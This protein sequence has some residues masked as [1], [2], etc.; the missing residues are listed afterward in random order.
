ME[1]KVDK[2]IAIVLAGVLCMACAPS[3]AKGKVASA[4]YPKV[5]H[6]VWQADFPTCKLPG[7][8]DSDVR[9]EIKP[10]KLIDYEQWNSP[11][12]VIQISR[13][14]QAWKISSRVHIDE[15]TFDHEEIY[16]LSGQDNGQLTIVDGNRA[17][18]YAR[19]R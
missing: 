8:L 7:N 17:I 13:S 2:A 16:A 5:L 11:V 15:S 18:T 19:C 1:F 6:G 9:I 14:P 12:R 4:H 10:D 3:V